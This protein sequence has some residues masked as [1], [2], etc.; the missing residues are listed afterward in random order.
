MIYSIYTIIYIS[1][2]CFHTQGYD[3]K[4]SLSWVL[5]APKVWNHRGQNRRDLRVYCTLWE[6]RDPGICAPNEAWKMLNLSVTSAEW[7]HHCLSGFGGVIWVMPCVEREHHCAPVRVGF[8]PAIGWSH[9]SNSL[10]V[11]GHS[12]VWVPRMHGQQLKTRSGKI[13]TVGGSKS[14]AVTWL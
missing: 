9:L 10:C 3:L 1:L 7:L 14:V 4:M 2:V 5:W 6:R 13:K 8:L 12:V 11:C